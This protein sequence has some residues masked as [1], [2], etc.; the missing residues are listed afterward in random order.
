MKQVLMMEAVSNAEIFV[1]FNDTA[2]RYIAVGYHIQGERFNSKDTRG[3]YQ[4][5]VICEDWYLIDS[6]KCGGVKLSRCDHPLIVKL[7]QKQIINLARTGNKL[8]KSIFQYFF[9]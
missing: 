3:T 5:C 6:S 2:R 9:A 7:H 8:K 1:Y 4:V